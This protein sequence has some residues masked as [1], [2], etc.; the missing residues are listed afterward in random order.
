MFRLFRYLKKSWVAAVAAPLFMLLEVTMDLL[1]PTLMSDVVD[2]GV[3]NG[4]LHYVWMMLGRMLGAAVI[5]L[6]GGAGCTVFSSIA[7]VSFGTE[8]RQDLFNAIQRFSFAELDTLQPASL[9]TRRCFE[10]ACR[11]MSKSAAR[12]A[13]DCGPSSLRRAISANRV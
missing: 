5:G 8:L 2:V 1:Q 6:I 9:I 13:I 7:G 3:A 11:E 12:L 10:I 4:D